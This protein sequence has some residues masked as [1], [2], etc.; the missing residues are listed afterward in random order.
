MRQW[1][2][3]TQHR[4]LEAQQKQKDT[5]SRKQARVVKEDDVVYEK[6]EIIHCWIYSPLS[7]VDVEKW[8]IEIAG[9]GLAYDKK[10]A[11]SKKERENMSTS[12]SLLYGDPQSAAKMSVQDDPKEQKEVKK[13][14][15]VSRNEKGIQEAQERYNRKT[16]N[17]ASTLQKKEEH[18]AK[19]G[20]SETERQEKL[21][22]KLRLQQL[23]KNKNLEM[24]HDERFDIPDELEDLYYRA[25]WHRLLG[26]TQEKTRMYN[27]IFQPKATLLRDGSVRSW[28]WHKNDASEWK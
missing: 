1:P 9:A 18:Q 15:K 20:R 10:I 6:K 19:E 22:V 27:L 11:K 7:E 13:P 24:P 12:T 28:S 25:V 26:D 17:V 23:L 2:A 8:V 14:M 21:Q 5:E 16:S 3:S 4:I